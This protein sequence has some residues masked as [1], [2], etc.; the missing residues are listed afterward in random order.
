MI[1]ELPNDAVCKEEL[2]WSPDSGC[3][4]RHPWADTSQQQDIIVLDFASASNPQTS[5]PLIDLSFLTATQE[6]STSSQP[7][8]DDSGFLT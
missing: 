6:R 8:V 1:R 4:L 7:A 2:L 3:S 5:E